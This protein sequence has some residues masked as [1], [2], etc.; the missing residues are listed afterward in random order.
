MR[1]KILTL[2]LAA[3]LLL[4]LFAAG[5][6]SST[7][8]SQADTPA[9]GDASTP[10]ASTPAADDGDVV[11]LGLVSGMTGNFA[12][13]SGEVKN[14]I[15][16]AISQRPEVLGKKVVLEVGDANDAAQALS[17]FERLYAKGVRVFMG[18][19]GAT[20]D[21]AIM[22]TID[23]KGAILVAATGW[24]DALTEANVKNLFHYTCRVTKFA[25]KLAE[26]GPMYAEEYLGVSKEDL[27]VAVVWNSNTE[28][29]AVPLLKALEDNGVNVAVQEGYPADRKDFTTLIAKM[30]SEGIHVF[31]PI[32]QSVD[33]IPFRKKLV[34]MQYEPPMTMA[35][36]NVY[37]QPDFGELGA[38]VVD[39]C[40][41]LS[42][43][44][45]GI[46]PDSAPGIAQFRE[47]YFN[48][49]GY[50]PLTHATQNYAG[51]LWTLDMIEEAG[52]YDVDKIYDAME[53]CD[54][55]AGVYP[56]Y[57]G[58]KY[59]E[60]HRNTLAA[61]PLAINQWQNAQLVVVGT[62][63]IAVGEC[64]VPWDASKLAD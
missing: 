1:R 60:Y 22:N 36:G 20:A 37:D 48:E 6:S 23:E 17:E 58:V 25:E 34:E 28:Y 41:V 33:G 59:D 2:A 21:L 8:P 54:I 19:F 24:S 44:H 49:H 10:A 16:Y 57:W 64:I 40:M 43:T 39:G 14:G 42:Y 35:F 32:Q 13:G 62:P 56:N 55:P 27:K 61:E 53:N 18:C 31:M 5:C 7:P 30:Q 50:Y 47:D 63:E 29:A 46:N 38:D 26:Y 12:F 11:Y 9:S 15:E 45:S 51:T 3:I 4:T 52:A